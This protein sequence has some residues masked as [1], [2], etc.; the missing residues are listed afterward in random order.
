MKGLGHGS[1]VIP[2][3]DRGE[4]LQ[5]RDFFRGSGGTGYKYEQIGLDSQTRF[6]AG[7]QGCLVTSYQKTFRITIT[8]QL[9]HHDNEELGP[10]P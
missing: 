9:Q 5:R 2:L 3:F 8:F 4:I 10:Y 1:V 6:V 7:L